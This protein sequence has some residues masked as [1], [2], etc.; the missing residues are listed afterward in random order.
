MR[1][2][3]FICQVSL[4]SRPGNEA[5]VW[6]AV[7]YLSQD[8]VGLGIDLCDVACKIISRL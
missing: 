1:R 6:C 3:F 7:N 8:V 2:Y 4:V 5:N